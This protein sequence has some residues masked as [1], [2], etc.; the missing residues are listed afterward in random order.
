MKGIVYEIYSDSQPHIKYVGST[1]KSLEKRWS[2]HKSDFKNRKKGTAIICKYFEEFGIYNFQIRSIKEYDIV[3]KKHLLAYEQLWINKLKSI[4]MIKNLF[5]IQNLIKKKKQIYLETYHKTYYTNNR[6]KIL[7]Q[8]ELY[9]KTNS[10][11]MREYKKK[12]Y[13]ENREQ[14]REKKQRTYI[15]PCSPDKEL[16]V[17][18]RSRHEQTLKHQKYLQS[19][20]ETKE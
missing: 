4:N 5:Q 12:W 3:D 9:N 8:N 1:I 17:S 2:Q 18:K 13:I 20:Q 16:T 15:C 7:K 10:E 6:E 14:I 19:L 11:H